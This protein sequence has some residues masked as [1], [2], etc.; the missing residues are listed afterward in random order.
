MQS[1][2]APHAHI[3]L[4]Q[5]AKD[6]LQR[7]AASSPSPS[8]LSSSPVPDASSE[9][10]EQLQ[11][12]TSPHKRRRIG[13]LSSLGGDSTTMLGAG[14][15]AASA[16]GAK[17]L[18]PLSFSQKSTFMSN[19]HT[20]GHNGGGVSLGGG[21]PV[22]TGPGRLGSKA[23]GKKLTIGSLKV[24][25]TLPPDFRDATWAKLDAALHAIFER[26]PLPPGSGGLED[27]YRASESLCH[28]H[29]AAWAYTRAVAVIRHH[30]RAA[31]GR[32]VDAITHPTATIKSLSWPTHA[33]PAAI[34][35]HAVDAAGE[36]LVAVSRAWSEFTDALK[37]ARAVLLF[38][39][40]TYAVPTEAVV[41]MYDRGI[42]E[43]RDAVL[44]GAATSNALAPPM[45]DAAA[46][47]TDP[48]TV[49]GIV[50]RA[51]IVLL[52]HVRARVLNP[53]E[54]VVAVAVPAAGEM[55]PPIG[56][57]AMTVMDA[58][59]SG[60]LDESAKD[61]LARVADAA[62]LVD[63]CG[64]YRSMLL[65][66][67]VAATS[68]AYRRAA[69]VRARDAATAASVTASTAGAGASAHGPTVYLHW[70]RAANY[71][72][73]A[74]ANRMPACTLVE[75]ARVLQDETVKEPRKSA[76]V[77][78]VPAWLADGAVCELRAMYDMLRP[79]A[80]ATDEV[81][82]AVAAWTRD[83]A[84]AVVLGAGITSTTSSSS[85]VPLAGGSSG[86]ASA[87]Q[88]PQLAPA[89]VAVRRVLDLSTARATAAGLVPA[90]ER[91]TVPVIEQLLV[92]KTHLE[93]LHAKCFSGDESIARAVHESFGVAIN[94]P[95][96][97]ASARTAGTGAPAELL[98]KY[99]DAVLKSKRT[100]LVGDGG[101]GGTGGGG[102]D[103][104]NVLG[105][106]LD[107]V[108]Q[109][110]RYLQAKD[111]FLAFYKSGLARRLLLGGA[112]SDDAE[113]AMVVRLRKECGNEVTDPL[114]VMFKD[115]KLSRD[116]RAEFLESKLLAERG[117]LPLDLDVI[118][119]QHSM[120]P[121]TTATS[122][123]SG[124]NS[125]NKDATTHHTSAVGVNVVLPKVMA[126]AVTLFSDFYKQQHS[127]RK[128]IWQ[129]DLG[130]VV[131]KAGAS[132]KELIMNVAQALIMLAFND[133]LQSNTSETPSWLKPGDSNP[134]YQAA[135]VLSYADLRSRTGLDTSVLTT[136]LQGLACGKLRLL[137]KHPAP[138]KGSLEI[139][140]TDLFVPVDKIATPKI[141]IKVPVV[142]PREIEAADADRTHAQVDVDRS[143]TVDAAIVRVM[144]ARRQ[145]SHNELLMEVIRQCSKR[146]EVTPQM[147]KKQVESLLERDYLE[148]ESGQTN[149]YNYMA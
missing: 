42:A 121:T 34:T 49:R 130:Q 32:L 59:Y 73:A 61:H 146:F 64:E 78:G 35:P 103:G 57:N 15:P 85:P 31:H 119:C 36:V 145:L 100:T 39:D 3:R 50:G 112:T 96:P 115:V 137:R 6:R 127:G 102:D 67:V 72:E 30:A 144:K 53:S 83:V 63:A 126:D 132:G 54:R 37:L 114:D 21:N 5:S 118:V 88:D 104:A 17:T 94:A 120:W 141:R 149:V 27:L 56:G 99:L 77:P 105:R 111:T 62:A 68:A 33:G 70:V 81:R 12:R 16:A 22:T 125:S 43:F 7:A 29:H 138:T 139:G 44:A 108:V 69:Q 106:V 14:P 86:S 46:A 4:S 41:P 38:L 95:L 84:R 136:T 82:A 98:A 47:A 89:V 11:Q 71:V 58:D 140:P 65:P 129:Y 134:T 74:V 123:A 18:A 109:V 101:G 60:A 107:E 87:S 92:L 26:R 110:F 2:P 80:G 9:S 8:P 91:I 124:D 24:A 143:G 28:H 66:T 75:L 90:S 13:P 133:P 147:F 131:V 23:F 116:F 135:P 117:P 142:V 128:L 76:I 19:S 10:Q 45:A 25:P 113:R 93:H 122:A 97:P 148:R 79:V 52:Q 51:V 40:R 20:G 55:V 1:S 48:G